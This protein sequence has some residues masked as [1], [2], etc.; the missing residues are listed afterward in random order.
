MHRRLRVSKRWLVLAS[1]LTAPCFVRGQTWI[2]AT[3]GSWSDASRW[4]ALPVPGTSTN[5]FFSPTGS[6]TYTALDDFGAPFTVGTLTFGGTSTGSIT[7]G[8]GLTSSL[9]FGSGT[10]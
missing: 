5:L 6:Q 1:A 3:D 2:S 4:S 8:S 10:W 9:R 7:L